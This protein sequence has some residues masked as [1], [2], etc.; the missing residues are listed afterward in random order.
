MTEIT[1]KDTADLKKLLK[2]K[3]EEVRASRFGVAGAAA[4]NVKTQMNARRE[5]AR[6]LT[7]LNARAKAVNG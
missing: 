1:K 2:E 4:R 7:E 6:I 3:R 5:I